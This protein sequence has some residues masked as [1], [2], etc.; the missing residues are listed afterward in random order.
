MPNVLDIPA[1]STATII[2]S[3]ISIVFSIGL[4]ISIFRSKKVKSY[5]HEFAALQVC[6]ILSQ[7]LITISETQ[8]YTQRYKILFEWMQLFSLLN[9]VGITLINIRILTIFYI[10]DDRITPEFIRKFWYTV[11]VVCSV[12]TLPQLIQ[13]IWI[14]IEVDAIMRRI[15][16]ITTGVWY[17]LTAVYD[18]YQLIYLFYLIYGKDRKFVKDKKLVC[19]FVYI[20]NSFGL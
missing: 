16:I 5:E 18:G 8:L 10:L 3:S 12:L 2:L 6:N 1:L 4:L 13:S 20:C 15:A 9:N 19:T 7:I 17:L 14:T 11:I